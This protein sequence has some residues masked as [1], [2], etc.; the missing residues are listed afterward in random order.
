MAQ[1]IGNLV[2]QLKFSD[3]QL[4]Q[5]QKGLKDAGVA[6]PNF[7]NVGR[8]LAKEINEE[9]EVE[10]ETEEERKSFY[11]I[12]CLFP[13]RYVQVEIAYYWNAK[14]RSWTCSHLPVVSLLENPEYT[15]ENV[16]ALANG[17]SLNFK[18]NVEPS[19]LGDLWLNNVKT[20][21]G[22]YLGLLHFKPL[23]VEL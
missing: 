10:E 18:L 23:L 22:F 9:P 16:C 1:R 15:L 6:M 11:L 4:Q 12:H 2:G 8:E 13:E 5:T 14:I 20:K 3:D 17:I 19:F 7:G 21:G